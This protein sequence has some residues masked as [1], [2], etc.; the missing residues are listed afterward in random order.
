[1]K[2]LVLI[3][4]LVWAVSC[5]P[6]YTASFHEYS[7]T[8]SYDQR[9]IN[10]QQKEI[11]IPGTT[12]GSTNLPEGVTASAESRPIKIKHEAMLHLYQDTII[13]TKQ[14]TILMKNGDAIVGQITQVTSVKLVCRVSEW[15][16]V[17]AINSKKH[18]VGT[19]QI[20][21]LKDVFLIKYA[22]GT[23]ESVNF[24][25][26]QDPAVSKGNPKKNAFAVMGIIF[27]L[28]SLFPFI[29]ILSS[30]LAIVFSI[31]GLKSE[32]RKLAK[33]GLIYGC[34]GL[35]LGVLWYILLFTTGWA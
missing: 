23:N 25:E 11:I 24:S 13:A 2:Y 7:H 29:G 6:K 12:I 8:P 22:N 18:F 5:A 19:N 15:K 21:L 10:K 1:M 33:R 17:R 28:F 31:L 35:V 4:C 30:P 32:K 27:G 34:I 3:N 20:I 26:K 9:A 16:T 14:D